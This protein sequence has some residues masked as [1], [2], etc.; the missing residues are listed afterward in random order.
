MRK[1]NNNGFTLVELIV[2][3]VILAILAAMLIPAL[4]GYIDRAQED[5]IK[6]ITRQVVVAAQ[7]VVSE[8]YGKSDGEFDDGAVMINQR[9]GNVDINQGGT[10]HKNISADEIVDI[11][12]LSE[13][14][15]SNFVYDETT[16]A[17]NTGFSGEVSQIIVT[18][19]DKGK[20]NQV[21]LGTNN[22]MCTYDGTTGEYTVTKY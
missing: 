9:S 15:P 14:V 18:W 20:V 4:T 17:T 21:F 2:V 1:R 5:K 12:I 7:T 22:R 3:L 10:P 19:T 6:T 8:A 16:G 13:V 11:L